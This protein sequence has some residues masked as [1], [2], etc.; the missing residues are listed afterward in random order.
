MLRSS[1]QLLPPL[2]LALISTVGC[3]ILGKS[4]PKS[5]SE[6]LLQIETDAANRDRL[7]E[8]TIKIVEVRA[9]AIGA[10]VKLERKDS[11]KIILRIGTTPDMERMKK[12]L[13]DYA[14]LEFRAVVSP[15]SPSPVRTY[16]SFDEAKAAVKEGEEVLPYPERLAYVEQ[17]DREQYVI[18]KAKPIIAN[19]DVRSAQAV[20]GDGPSHEI[21]FS[22][23]PDGA[24]RFG[25]W[26]AANINNYLAVALN[27]EVK[28]VAYIRSQITDSGVITGS[29]TKAAAEDLALVLR[30][31]SLPTPINVLAEKTFGK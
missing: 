23:K 24:A 12:V 1:K 21:T 31:G 28:S 5:G 10:N 13:L 15:P 29:F 26:T 17:P 20:P 9:N 19:E 4:E 16:P 30:S 7:I 6:L 14:R 22:L 3:N 18:V 2:L 27:K 25:E 8:Q 11:D